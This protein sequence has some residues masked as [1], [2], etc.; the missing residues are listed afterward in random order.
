MCPTIGGEVAS[1]QDPIVKYVSEPLVTGDLYQLGW[2]EVSQEECQR[3]RGGE[4]GLIMRELFVN[5]M[6]KL[7]PEFMDRSMAESLIGRLE[8]LKTNI[9]GSLEAWEFLKGLKTVFVP[10]E[11]R[12]RNVTMIDADHLDRNVFNVTK[13]F[14]FD[15]GNKTNRADVVFL[16]NG[17]PVLILEAKAAHRIDGMDIAMNQIRRYHRETPEMMT[18]NQLY[19]ITHIVKFYYSATWNEST[20][21]IFNWK[22]EQAGNYEELVKSFFDRRR[23]VR[24]LHD[25]ILFTRADDE[26]KK[27]VL[28]PHQMRA[29]QKIEKRAQD[30]EKDRGLIWHTQGSGK[31]Y[32]MIVAAEQL[33]NNKLFENP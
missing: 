27:V 8:R 5:Q 18:L 33:I 23:I 1:V 19:T 32:S 14:S 17:V 20:K 3:C 22:D 28:R 26:L 16:I 4:T 12:E 10:E 13:E 21:W 6:M 25:Y 15:N 11:N 9:E 24:L 31:T 30:P 29:V 7:N 2:N